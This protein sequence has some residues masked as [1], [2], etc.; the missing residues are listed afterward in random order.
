MNLKVWTYTLG[1]IMTLAGLSHFI[2]TRK[3]L[4][5]VPRFLPQR[6][7]IIVISGVIELAA[8]MGLFIPLFQKEAAL[9][10]LVLMVG[11]LPLHA[12]DLFRSRPAI[13]PH[14]LAAIR[15]ALQFLLIYWAWRVWRAA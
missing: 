6:M 12:W 10:V 15:F 14:W 2:I 13:G 11:F 5:I 8:G 3:Y 9:V 4:P 7:G 1:V